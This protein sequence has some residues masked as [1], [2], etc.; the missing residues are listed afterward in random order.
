MIS[1][2]AEK[3]QWVTLLL[4]GL[5]N[6]I[7][8]NNYCDNLHKNMPCRNGRIGILAQS[9]VSFIDKFI[10]RNETPTTMQEF[11]VH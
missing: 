3:R 7:Q 9:G 8:A 11:S 10:K 1:S 6:L 4:Q 2:K 5:A